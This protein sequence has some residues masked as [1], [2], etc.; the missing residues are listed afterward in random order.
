MTGRI[1]FILLISLVISQLCFMRS[2]RAQNSDRQYRMPLKDVLQQIEA[3]FGVKIK[4]NENQVKDRNLTYAL[5]RFRPTVDETLSQVLAPLDLKVNKE[6][7]GVYKLK[8]YEYY[9]WPVQEGWEKLDTLAA[10]YHDKASWEL[11]KDSLRKELWNAL[12]L[13]P[14]PAKPVSKPIVTPV[15]KMDGYTVQNIALEILPGLYVNGSLYRPMKAKG[16]IPVVLSP[17]G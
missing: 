2:T 12:K 11:R 1:S 7:E 5:W 14:L 9:R 6:K 16:K 3:R 13:S 17:D 15:R 4:Y 10:R 8:E